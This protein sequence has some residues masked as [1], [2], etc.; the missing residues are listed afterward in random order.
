MQ[1]PF[2]TAREMGEYFL[3]DDRFQPRS[4]FDTIDRGICGQLFRGQA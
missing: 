3:E 2:K 1:I 4:V